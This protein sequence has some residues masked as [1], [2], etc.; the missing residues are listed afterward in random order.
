M[1][2]NHVAIHSQKEGLNI[3]HVN[4][5]IPHRSQDITWVFSYEFFHDV[6]KFKHIWNWIKYNWSNAD[7]QCSLKKKKICL[8]LIHLSIHSSKKIWLH[9]NFF[10]HT[11]SYKVRYYFWPWSKEID[12]VQKIL[13]TVKRIWAWSIYFWSSKWNSHNGIEYFLSLKSAT[14]LHASLRYIF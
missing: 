12:P 6:R 14:E 2:A 9:Q 3:N 5:S 1:K 7:L 11:Q 8:C 13:N 4:D 10:D